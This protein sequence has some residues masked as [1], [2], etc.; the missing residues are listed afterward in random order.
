MSALSP[1][2][3]VTGSA[4]M[5]LAGRLLG[6]L[7]RPGDVIALSGPL[8]AG[9][10]SLVQGVAAG[11]GFTGHV[12]SPTFNILLVHRG[13]LPLHHFDLYRLERADQ[14]EDI[15][16][17]EMLESGGVS[18]IEWAERF[19]GELPDD[20]LEVT[21]SVPD[22][23]TRAIVPVGTGPRGCALARAWEDA[24]VREAAR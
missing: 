10:T 17:Y 20:R 4:Q 3:T 5:H 14:L 7:A 15:G 19:P 13:A 16:F 24:W 23:G 22:E 11:L 12:P 8:G 21:I 18:A 6:E 9:K 2:L 1:L